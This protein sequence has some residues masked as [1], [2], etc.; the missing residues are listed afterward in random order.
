[1]PSKELGPVTDSDVEHRDLESSSY[2]SEEAQEG[3]A[4]VEALAQAWGKWGLIIAYVGLLLGSIMA[5]LEVMTTNAYTPAA[6]SAFKLHSLLSTV[7]VVTSILAASVKPPVAKIA[8]VFGRVEA[9]SISLF[10]LILGFIMKAASNNV[11][12]YAAS[13]IFSSAG[14]TGII[15]F[16]QIFIADSTSLLNRA[17][18]SSLP[19]LPYLF[20]TWAGPPFA[21]AVGP[22]SNWRWGYGMWAIIYPV[23][24]F[25]L[26]AS[27]FANQHR[28]KKMGLIKRKERGPMNIL[29]MIKNTATDLDLMGLL[30]LTS[31]LIMLLVPLTLT[32]TVGT[33]PW[34][35]AR[36]IC[37]VVFGAVVLGLFVGWET[38]KK[39]CAR[40]M[41]SLRFIA[42]PTIGSAC[43][44]GFFY[45]FVYYLPGAYF[46]T[47]LQVVRNYTVTEAGNIANTFTFSSSTMSIIISLVIKYTGHYKWWMMSGIPLY[48]LGYGLMIAFRTSSATTA[49]I[50]IAQVFTGIGGGTINVPAQVGL[51]AA[52]KHQDVAIA[53]AMFLT[54]T[55]VGGAV[56]N[57][58]T[59][60]IWANLLPGYL[61]D[62][63][64]NTSAADQVNVIY[65]NYFAALSYPMGSPER[66]AINKA[67]SD[68]YRIQLIVACCAAVPM[69]P[70][71]LW[72][73]NYDLTKVNFHN[74]RGIVIGNVHTDKS[75]S[76]DN[77]QPGEPEPVEVTEAE[78]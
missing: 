24:Y 60:A 29:A 15:I 59:G 54:F 39:L 48:V 33:W 21:E 53:T 31:G 71:G 46:Y 43:A 40:P 44:L 76:T 1:M 18:F 4:K 19:D 3:V 11:D 27:L 68:V 47:W 52:C 36:T 22:E 30:L 26:L 51:Q 75:E 10:L 16:T 38:T 50:V 35:S 20:T 64:A 72:M 28:A 6:T 37:L 57:A 14:S 23:A 73:K 70:L 7:G 63:L 77:T 25:P 5:S 8:D 67:Y 32:G 45:F 58:V 65:G 69:V 55:S 56:G 12:T 66:I 41:M 49:Q 17:L 62:A 9:L 42:D 34:K 61:R 74:V 78:Q 13:S 2:S